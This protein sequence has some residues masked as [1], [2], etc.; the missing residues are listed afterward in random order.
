M[1]SSGECWWVG[2]RQE[3]C[4][5]SVWLGTF[6]LLQPLGLIQSLDSEAKA[7]ETADFANVRDNLKAVQVGQAGVAGGRGRGCRRKGRWFGCRREGQGLQA[8]GALVCVQEGGHCRST[9]LFCSAVQWNRGNSTM[10]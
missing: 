3:T 1:P 6:P 5:A 9:L 2:H 7:P 4:R 10:G 8:E